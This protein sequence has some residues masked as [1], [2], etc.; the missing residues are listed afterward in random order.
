MSTQPWKLKPG[1]HV[2]GQ[3]SEDSEAGGLKGAWTRSDRRSHTLQPRNRL[4]WLRT[5]QRAQPGRHR[6][7]PTP[8]TRQ[9]HTVGISP[10]QQ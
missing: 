2:R 6:A 8:S 5:S 9:C 1:H 10:R 4:Q 7:R 3:D